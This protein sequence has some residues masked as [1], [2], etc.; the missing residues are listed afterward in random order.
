MDL[1]TRMEEVLERMEALLAEAREL[2]AQMASAMVTDELTGLHNRR[3]LQIR[4]AEELARA[5]RHGRPLALLVLDLDSIKVCNDQHGHV[6]GDQ[7][8]VEVSELLRSQARGMDVVVRMGGDEFIILAPDTDRAGGAEMAQRLLRSLRNKRFAGGKVGSLTASVG[9]AVFPE[10]GDTVE[11]LLRR[12]DDAMYRAKR[13]GKDQVRTAR[14]I[15]PA[16]PEEPRTEGVGDAA[17]GETEPAS[18]E[19]GAQEPSLEGDLGPCAQAGPAGGPEL[20]LRQGLAAPVAVGFSP[21]RHY[22]VSF[23]YG[24]ELVQVQA[25][26]DEQETEDGASYTVQT[27]FGVFRLFR[28]GERWYL[29]QA[30][31]S[32]AQTNGAH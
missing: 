12:A 26:F 18:E 16:K 23:W 10:D 3:F 5:R 24:D 13:A 31:P 7:V 1:R 4:F 22:P 27:T 20:C 21:E 19:A 28:S 14:P 25:I 29:S 6:V 15:E 30:A 17:D 8:L 2:S 32:A 11:E 9:V